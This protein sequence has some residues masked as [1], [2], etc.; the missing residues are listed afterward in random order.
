M[1]RFISIQLFICTVAFG[2]LTFEA[3]NQVP[4]AKPN[5]TEFKAN[6]RF[7]NT[8]K[9]TVTIS[10]LKST[11]ACLPAELKKKIEAQRREPAGKDWFIEVDEANDLSDPST[12]HSLCINCHLQRKAEAKDRKGPDQQGSDGSGPDGLDEGMPAYRP[13]DGLL[14]AQARQFAS[15]SQRAARDFLRRLPLPT[16]ERFRPTQ[17][18]ATRPPG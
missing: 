10:K 17:S 12:A 4:K 2:Q 8:G 11:C 9:N 14:V 5:E 18:S 7:M 13:L 16:V 15:D 6:Y 3:P 1:I